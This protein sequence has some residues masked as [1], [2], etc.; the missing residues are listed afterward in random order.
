[1]QQL[2]ASSGDRKSGKARSGT[3]TTRPGE[4]KAMASDS[5]S[6]HPGNPTWSDEKV[7]GVG[8]LATKRRVEASYGC[9]QRLS[10]HGIDSDGQSV[11]ELQP[12]KQSQAPYCS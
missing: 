5:P 9:R 8:C 4:A 7:D 1:M 12:Q 6:G 10:T 11:L 2:H 3:Q